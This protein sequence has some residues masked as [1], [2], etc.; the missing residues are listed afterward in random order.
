MAYGSWLS[1]KWSSASSPTYPMLVFSA[2]EKRGWNTQWYSAQYAYEVWHAVKASHPVHLR[3]KQFNKIWTVWLF[4]FLARPDNAEAV[5][6]AVT[7]WHIWN[8]W[9]VF[10]MV[11]PWSNR[12][13]YLCR[14]IR[15][16]RRSCSIFLSPWCLFAWTLF[17]LGSATGRCTCRHCWCFFVLV[18]ISAQSI[19]MYSACN[20]SHYTSQHNPSILHPSLASRLFPTTFF[21]QKTDITS[22]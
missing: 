15:T 1:R 16:S 19:Q 7:A 21:V 13:V 17:S 5:T 8:A 11:K 20:S 14:L 22:Q 12:T 10:V 3:R 2:T 18:Y 9:N 6:L 4:D